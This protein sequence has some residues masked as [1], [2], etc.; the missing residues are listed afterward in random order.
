MGKVSDFLKSEIL[1]SVFIWHWSVSAPGSG[2]DRKHY[3]QDCIR[4]G[5]DRLG[6]YHIV[7]YTAEKEKATI[8]D[9]FTGVIVMVLGIFLFFTPQIVIKILPYLLGAL[10]LVDSIWKIKG[11]YRLKKAQRGR[12]KIILIGCLVFI[13]LGVS[14]LLYSFLSVTRMILFSGIILTADGVADIVF[15]IMIRLGMKKSEKLCAEKEQEENG[16]EK[17]WDDSAD[18]GLDEKVQDKSLNEDE[19]EWKQDT[20]SQVQEAE[21]EIETGKTADADAILDA[22]M[23]TPDEGV[24]SPGREIREMLKNHDEPLEEWKD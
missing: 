23:Q 8:L 2:P 14:M 6:I 10:L 24:E 7:I 22:E 1:S 12:W 9:L 20:D 18:A 11:S 19:T 13:A 5:N 16:K 15:L 17:P 21:M 4:T 3:L